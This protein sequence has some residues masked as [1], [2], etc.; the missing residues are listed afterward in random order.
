MSG[1]LAID[2]DTEREME[3]LYQQFEALR[4]DVYSYLSNLKP[5]LG[6]FR[7]LVSSPLPTWKKT[8]RRQLSNA[9]LHHVIKPQTEFDEIFCLISQYISW[10]GYELLKKIVD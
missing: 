7:V 5:N 10:H 2:P 1:E 6:E 3:Q 9:D 8:S 4:M